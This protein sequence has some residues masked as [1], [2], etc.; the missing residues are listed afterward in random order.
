MKVTRHH[1]EPIRLRLMTRANLQMQADFL[2]LMIRLMTVHMQSEDSF[3]VVQWMRN[4]K[5]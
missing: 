1:Y 5:P 4:M 2:P 3:I